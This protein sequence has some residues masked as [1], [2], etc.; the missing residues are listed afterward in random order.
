MLKLI[1][2][3][4]LA[5]SQ[6]AYL[7]LLDRFGLLKGDLLAL[8]IVLHV[9]LSPISAA[10]IGFKLICL[11]CC[12]QLSSLQRSQKFALVNATAEWLSGMSV[13]R[14]AMVALAL[15]HVVREPRIS[16]IAAQVVA[17]GAAYLFCAKVRGRKDPSLRRARLQM[18]MA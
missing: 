12:L 9:A 10:A 14:L 2:K 1:D 5:A 7:H 3:R 13:L 18:S 11:T 15:M 8:L 16:V 6:A 17:L 4:L